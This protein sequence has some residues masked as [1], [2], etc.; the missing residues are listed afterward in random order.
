MSDQPVLGWQEGQPDNKIRFGGKT[1][2]ERENCVA[3]IG[4]SWHMNDMRC[5]AKKSYIC[6]KTGLSIQSH[7][8][9]L[10]T[11]ILGRCIGSVKSG[12]PWFPTKYLDS[13]RK[14][15]YNL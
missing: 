15:F 2:P 10:E 4:A 7:H 1:S 12:G 3:L 9:M 8:T 11:A 6:E 14:T 13:S 5:S